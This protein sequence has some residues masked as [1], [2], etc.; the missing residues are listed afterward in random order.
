MVQQSD[1]Q[2]KCVTGSPKVVANN[3]YTREFSRVL[4]AQR[5]IE[6][7]QLETAARIATG[8]ISKST[9]KGRVQAIH[10]VPQETWH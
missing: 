2:V 1:A 6:A 8:S 5:R 9:G 10:I 7:P 3:E 4:I